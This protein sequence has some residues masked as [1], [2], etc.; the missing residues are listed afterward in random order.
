MLKNSYSLRS[1]ESVLL[2]LQMCLNW[3]QIQHLSPSDSLGALRE[4]CSQNLS[5]TGISV[6]AYRLLKTG[7]V[8]QTMNYLLFKLQKIINYRTVLDTLV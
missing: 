6:L 4:M 3:Y 7:N 2:D 8:Q 1:F 5:I